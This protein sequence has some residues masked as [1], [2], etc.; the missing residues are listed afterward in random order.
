MQP[1]HKLGS[2]QY[3]NQWEKLSSTM[4]PKSVSSPNM[5]KKIKYNNP[6]LIWYIYVYISNYALVV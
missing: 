5:T 4:M 6:K 1:K 2:T 3:S